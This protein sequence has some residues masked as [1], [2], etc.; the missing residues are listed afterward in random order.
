MIYDRTSR[1]R[2]LPRGP[3]VR[4]VCGCGANSGGTPADIAPSIGK[5]ASE[6]MV[7]RLVTLAG[8]PMNSGVGPGPTL[9]LCRCFDVVSPPPSEVLLPVP[10][11]MSLAHLRREVARL[12]VA[13]RQQMDG[14]RDPKHL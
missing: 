5:E 8:N 14:A 12:Q 11:P 7:T 9:M 4:T 1:T 3:R 13:L 2:A 6:Q 10:E